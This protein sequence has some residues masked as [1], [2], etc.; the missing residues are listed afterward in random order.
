LA[1]LAASVTLFLSAASLA[2]Q[3]PAVG[4]PSNLPE[5][6]ATQ[7]AA[8]AS[9]AAE[10]DPNAA[11]IAGT[12][13]DTN[14]DIVP[15]ANVTLEGP[16]PEDRRTTVA[17][18]N[19]SFEFDGLKPGVP[20]QVAIQAKGFVD[21][22]SD[23][24]KLQSGEFHFV[25]D[26]RLQLLGEA[27]SITVTASSPEEI[28][29][30]Q[31]QIEEQ[32]RVLGFIPNFYVAYD[33]K[34]AVPLTTKLKFQMAFRVSVDPVSFLGAAFLGA[35]DQAAD[36]PNF[37]QGWNGYGK[38]VGSIYAD[39]L[40]DIMFG[41]AILPSLLHQDPR[42]F[43]QGTGTIKSRALH[44]MSNPYVCRGDNGKLQPNYSSLGGDLISSAISNAYYPASNRG[45]AFTFEGVAIATAERT[46]SSLI[47]EFVIRKLTPSAKRQ[48]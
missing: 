39:G 19:A 7:P 20:Y 5:A 30:Q 12:V 22:N 9:G 29:T 41:G 18:D 8:S 26:V 31:V 37:P 40:T 1:T 27:T 44:A 16:T 33:A 15:E 28:A 38:R 34:N 47:Q 3:Q 36:N 14:G 2:A 6:P 42:Y 45:A 48:N 24:L 4:G 32:Q 43:Y 23:A 10:T 35:I 11:R 17:S 46:V 25:T 13:T 21:W